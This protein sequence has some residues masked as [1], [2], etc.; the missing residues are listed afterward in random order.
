MQQ[1]WGGPPGSLV[2]DGSCPRT[3]QTRFAACTAVLPPLS[4]LER[5]PSS[6]RLRVGVVVVNLMAC[7]RE[8][9]FLLLISACNFHLVS[10]EHVCSILA[11][12]LRNLRGQQRTRLLNKFTENDSE[13]VSECAAVCLQPAGSSAGRVPGKAG[14]L[15][16]RAELL[17][18]SPCPCLWRPV[19]PRATVL[20]FML[21]PA[22]WRTGSA[23]SAWPPA[24]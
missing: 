9:K 1:G 12:L 10:L 13:K 14:C 7:Y 24:S 23:S 8:N 16:A 4:V 11:S 18:G 5:K 3:P 20:L 17:K 21:L 22:N 2:M 19:H 6:S 15:Q